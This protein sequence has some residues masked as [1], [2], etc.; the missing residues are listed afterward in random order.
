MV[1]W[2]R[3]SMVAVSVSVNGSLLAVDVEAGGVA[4]VYAGGVVRGVGLQ[5]WVAT[6]VARQWGTKERVLQNWVGWTTTTHM[7]DGIRHQ[8]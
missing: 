4:V 5:L 3:Q 8:V 2:R 6:Q 1:G 7:G